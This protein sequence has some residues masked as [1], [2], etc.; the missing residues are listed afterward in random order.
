MKQRCVI[1][2]TLLQRIYAVSKSLQTVE[3]KLLKGVT[4]LNTLI[5]FVDHFRVDFTKVE[6]SAKEIPDIS[7]FFTTERRSRK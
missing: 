4:L 5:K 1:W 3:C 2:N 7:S 6:D